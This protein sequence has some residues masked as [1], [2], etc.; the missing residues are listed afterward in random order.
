MDNRREFS[1]AKARE[2]HNLLITGMCG[3]GKTSI[4]KKLGLAI[5]TLS[6]AKCL[7]ISSQEN[8]DLQ[9]PHYWTLQIKM[10]DERKQ[11]VK[12]LVIVIVKDWIFSYI[13]EE[14]KYFHHKNTGC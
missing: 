3:T 6:S 13:Q 8:W 7:D 2:G 5:A 12:V 9:L 11:F 14:V 10:S 1:F 4:V